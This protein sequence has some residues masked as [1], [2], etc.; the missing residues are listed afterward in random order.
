MVT[1]VQNKIPMFI[2]SSFGVNNFPNYVVLD[3]SCPLY[4]L[5]YTKSNEKVINSFEQFP[6]TLFDKRFILDT[7]DPT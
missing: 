5:D 6:K 4:N 7:F 2:T 3:E 1:K